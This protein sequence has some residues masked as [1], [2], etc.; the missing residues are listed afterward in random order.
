MG[1]HGE[2]Q[3]EPGN[4]LRDYLTAAMVEISRKSLG[5]VLA[6]NALTRQTPAKLLLGEIRTAA[7]HLR[8][9]LHTFVERAFLERM[10]GVMVDKDS[11]RSLRREKMRGV[12]DGLR[13]ER[14]RRRTFASRRSMQGGCSKFNHGI[15]S[16]AGS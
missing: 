7:E 16:A 10:Q 5:E 3:V 2:S 14:L 6:A 4:Q 8:T 9:L 13:Q 11:D 15:L 1:Q 12:L